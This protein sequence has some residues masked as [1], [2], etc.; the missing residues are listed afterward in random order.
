MDNPAE[1]DLDDE[2]MTS[3]RFDVI[4]VKI[5]ALYKHPGSDHCHNQG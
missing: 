2:D 1:V 3:Q 4:Q 5:R